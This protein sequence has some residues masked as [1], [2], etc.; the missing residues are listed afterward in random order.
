[1][2]LGY[3]G[4]FVLAALLLAGGSIGVGAFAVVVYA[5]SRFMLMAEGIMEGFGVSYRQSIRA[6]HL[7]ELLDRGEGRPAGDRAGRGT[8]GAVTARN[9]SFTY[10]GADAAAVSDVNVDLAPGTTVAAGRGQRRRQDHAGQAA[11]GALRADRR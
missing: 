2:L 3:G 8:G 7:V 6:S 11:P 5:M 1:M 9:V 4:S 10:P